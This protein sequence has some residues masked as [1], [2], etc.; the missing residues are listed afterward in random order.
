[1]AVS[2]MSLNNPRHVAVNMLRLLAC[3]ERSPLAFNHISMQRLRE[4]IDAL[5]QMKPTVAFPD[6]LDLDSV[7]RRV[8]A[9]MELGRSAKSV[10]HQRVEEESSRSVDEASSSFT[11]VAASA[12][13]GND[14]Y[15]MR[16]AL[17]TPK[18]AP[19][20]RRMAKFKPEKPP[21]GG[22]VSM[23]NLRSESITKMNNQLKN[24]MRDIQNTATK[25]CIYS[26]SC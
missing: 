14:E 20:R 12:V 10:P 11:S 25:V 16:L 24:V 1:M 9:I 5:H 18:G 23:Q 22:S 17:L 3:I 26:V 2:S 6:G 7:D 19:S 15:D 8:E 4:Q 13:L 21:V